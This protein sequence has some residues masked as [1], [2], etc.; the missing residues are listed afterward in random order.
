MGF[1]D[2]VDVSGEFFD[3]VVEVGAGDGVAGGPGAPG[4]DRLD[5]GDVVCA[6]VAEID[7]SAVVLVEPLGSDGQLA[8]RCFSLFG[9]GLV[10]GF[11]FIDA[12]GAHGCSF[13]RC[14]RGSLERASCSPGGVA[15]PVAGGPGGGL[16]EV[17]LAS[18]L[19]QVVLVG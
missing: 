15:G 4:A 1:G 12:T 17:R 13:G 18:C 19:G 5:E 14:G 8:T 7:G 10:D 6:V 9:D 11:E 2:G 16:V 3:C